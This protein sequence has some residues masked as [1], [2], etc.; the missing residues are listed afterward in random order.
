MEVFFGKG[1]LNQHEL[2][3][4]QKNGLAKFLLAQGADLK[5]SLHFIDSI[6][7][8]AGHAAVA[9]VLGQKQIQKRWEG[10]SQLALALH[11][12]LPQIAEKMQKAKK[13]A[14]QKFQTVSRSLPANLPIESIVIQNDFFKN[15]DDTTC[16]QIQKISPNVSGIIVMKYSELNNGLTAMQLCRK[17]N[18]PFLSLVFVDVNHLT[19]AK[20]CRSQHA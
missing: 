19:C 1:A 4:Q 8:G 13:K 20:K 9:S 6:L 12:P 11:V 3:V 15:Q 10:L 16:Q 18:W 14:Q 2:N 17:T 7:R 5:E